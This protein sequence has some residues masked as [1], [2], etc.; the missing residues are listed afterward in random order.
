MMGDSA[1]SSIGC[2]LRSERL[3]RGKDLD[4]IA[5]QTKISRAILQAIE[6]DQFESLPGGAYRKGF[7][8]QYARA[9][10]L[11]ED[12]SLA[13]FH[14]QHLELPVPLPA[15][16]PAR[17]LRH[18]REA[19]FLFLVPVAVLGFYKVAGNDYSERKH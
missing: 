4:L 18:L 6:N 8:R 12:D 11:D 7:V 10:G 15:V 13:A 2:M 16:P 19:A 5:A 1:A 9:L 14:R 3:R 17:P